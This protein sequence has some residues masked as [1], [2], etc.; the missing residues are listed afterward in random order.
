MEHK[1][2]QEA[3]KQAICIIVRSR[4]AS[5][6]IKCDRISYNKASTH[7]KSNLR[8]YQK[9]IA[10]LIYTIIF[11]TVLPSALESLVSVAAFFR[12]C[13]SLVSRSQTLF[14]R[15]ALIDWKL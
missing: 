10:G 4:D 15:T 1:E 2:W 3:A 9:W 13:Q 11:H 6:N 7:T 14:L 8:F 12:P 5:H